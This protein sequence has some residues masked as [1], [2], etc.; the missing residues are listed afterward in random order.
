MSYSNIV[1]F[2]ITSMDFAEVR[3]ERGG[4]PRSGEKSEKSR[5][6]SLDLG[7]GEICI[8][9]EESL[10]YL[11]NHLPLVEEGEKSSSSRPFLKLKKY[12]EEVF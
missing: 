6:E 9:C 5:P 4:G 3:P 1:P 10:D 8:F 7:Q 12:Q 2:L 11:R